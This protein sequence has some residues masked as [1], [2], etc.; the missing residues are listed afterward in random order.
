MAG[1]DAVLRN[2]KSGHSPAICAGEAGI[3]TVDPH[4]TGGR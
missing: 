4:M 2:F 1:F 3:S